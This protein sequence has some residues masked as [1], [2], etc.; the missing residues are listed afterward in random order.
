MSDAINNTVA[1]ELSEQELDLVAGGVSISLGDGQ[2]FASDAA[3]SFEQKNLTLGQQTSAG[4][5]GS[6]TVSMTNLQDI[7][8]SAAQGIATSN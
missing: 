8:S 5:N 2:G 1:V 3:N 4:P 6:S 7:L